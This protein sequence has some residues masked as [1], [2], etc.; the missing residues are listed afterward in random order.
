M[1]GR[2]TCFE[3][4]WLRKDLNAVGSGLIGWILNFFLRA[5]HL[6]TARV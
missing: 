6:S 2:L 3:R 5:F 4:D 1:H